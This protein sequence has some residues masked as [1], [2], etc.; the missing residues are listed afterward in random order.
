MIGKKNRYRSPRCWWKWIN[1]FLAIVCTVCCFW[2][3]F[4][5]RDNARRKFKNRTKKRIHRYNHAYRPQ[6][7]VFQIPKDQ[8]PFP[9][10]QGDVIT[11]AYDSLKR[12]SI[13]VD[14]VII[15]K[16]DD[17]HWGDTNIKQIAPISML[18]LMCCQY[19]N[20]SPF[21]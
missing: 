17:L 1:D 9:I 8:K 16:R 15:R 10:Q 19:K 4:D 2:I 13:P 14:P 6:G 18:C 7:T 12:H 3:P 21:F 5:T 11:I 20:T